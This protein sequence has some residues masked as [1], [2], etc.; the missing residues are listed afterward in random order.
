MASSHRSTIGRSAPL[1]DPEGIKAAAEVLAEGGVV[2]H[3]FANMY[4][5]TAR[6]DRATV[7]RVNLMKGRPADQ[8][9]SITTTPSRIPSVFDWSRLPSGLTHRKLLGLIDALYV[10]GPFGFR[11]PA[12][13]HVPDHLTQADA[14]VRTTQVIAPGYAC[15]SNAFLAKALAATG[16][17]F[18][19]VTSANRSRKLTGAWE[20]PAHWRAA[21]LKAEFDGEPGITFLEHA[22]EEAARRGYPCHAPMSTTVLAFHKTDGRDDDGR[23]RLVVERHGS[24]PVELLAPAVAALGYGLSLSPGAARRLSQ[25]SYDDGVRVGDGHLG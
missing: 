23:V 13:A 22:D 11:G 18:L 15:P 14:G 17:D 25:R 6:P 7:G 8:V 24:L 1:T 3:G 4:A 9:G 2:A 16:E 21:A 12:A 5:L 10:L 19:Y 20:E